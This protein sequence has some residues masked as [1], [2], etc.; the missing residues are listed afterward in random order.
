MFF[1]FVFCVSCGEQED[2][3]ENEE[4]LFPSAG[5]PWDYQ[6]EKIL[7]FLKDTAGHG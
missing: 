6:F 4:P 5:T 2:I 3:V 1:F 7:P